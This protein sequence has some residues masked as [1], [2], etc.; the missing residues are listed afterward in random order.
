MKTLFCIDNSSSV[1]H[2]TVYHNITKKVFNEFS[3]SKGGYLIYFWG[4]TIKKVNES[5]F[6]EWNKNKEGCGGT[7]SELIADVIIN[8]KNY[9]IEHLI[10]ITDG[11]VDCNSIDESDEKMK[12]NNIHFKYVSTYIIG[13]GGDR[14]VGA[15]YCRGDPNVTYKY[16][17]ETDFEKLASLNKEQINLLDSFDKINSYSEFI[18]NF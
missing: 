17:T 9:G 18:S 3:K 6:R 5:E 2:E 15:P 16:N 1:R 8:E 13:S 12:Q 4:S 14:S 7:Q 10:I 11:Q